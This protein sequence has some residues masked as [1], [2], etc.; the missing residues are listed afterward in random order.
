L[1]FVAFTFLAIAFPVGSAIFFGLLAV[2]LVG[3]GAM[4]FG[5]L[6]WKLYRSLVRLGLKLELHLQNAGQ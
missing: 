4:L 3:W 2:A 1:A 5:I 6:R